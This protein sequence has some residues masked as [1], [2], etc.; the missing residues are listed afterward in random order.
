MEF[1]LKG[2]NGKITVI[3]IAMVKVGNVKKRIVYEI[4]YSLFVVFLF[5]NLILVSRKIFIKSRIFTIW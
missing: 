1:V 3:Y 5:S 2:V 4:K